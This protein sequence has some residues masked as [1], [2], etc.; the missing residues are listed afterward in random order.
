[1]RRAAIAVLALCL[2]GCSFLTV[3]RLEFGY[4]RDTIPKCSASIL[5]V[6][7]DSGAAVVDLTM[8]GAMF[9][10]AT[11]KE[12][13]EDERR[14]Y[15]N[16]ALYVGAW[17]GMFVASAIY[18]IWQKRRCNGARDSHEKWILERTTPEVA[19]PGPPGA[20]P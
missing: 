18:G 19:P 1:M 2:A 5:P 17:G 8:M 6:L 13:P 11:D 4:R 20:S 14:A 7:A 3:E 9:D 16:Q 12:R 15:W 10:L